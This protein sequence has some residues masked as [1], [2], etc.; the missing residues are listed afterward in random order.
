MLIANSG[1]TEQ[2]FSNSLI[3]QKEKTEE[4]IIV[5]EVWICEPNY[6]KIQ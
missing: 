1:D 3:T 4:I 2:T 6:H 5:K